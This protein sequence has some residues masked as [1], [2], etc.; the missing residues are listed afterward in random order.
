MLLIG[1]S[2]IARGDG[3]DVGKPGR[4][5]RSRHPVLHP[6]PSPVP[7]VHRTASVFTA[8]AIFAS[9]LITGCHRAALTTSSS[10]VWPPE[11]K[12]WWAPFRTALPPDSVAVRFA[13]AYTMLGLSRAEWS[14]QA[15]TAWAQ[16]GP[17]VLADSGRVGTYAARV[18]AFRRGDSTLLRTFVAIGSSMASNVARERIGF[19]GETIRTAKPAATAPRIEEPDDALPV[20]RRR[21]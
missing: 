20:W 6:E 13:R 17:S 15:D 2:C 3:Q 7:P 16:A 1:S 5:L 19:C 10:S 14:H 18:V 4:S 9:L 11:G 12:C 21:S 8:V